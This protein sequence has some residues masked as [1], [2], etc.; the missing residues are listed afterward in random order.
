M[1]LEV[2]AGNEG[3]AT[4]R[5]ADTSL[6][7]SSLAEPSQ[8]YCPQCGAAVERDQHIC[9]RCGAEVEDPDDRAV[10]DAMLAPELRRARYWIL[11]LGAL[12]TVT[13]LLIGGFA[14]SVT[15]AAARMVI[16]V[17]VALGLIH[18]GLFFWAKTQPLAA[19]VV[20]LGLFI[21]VNAINA[22]DDPSTLA[23]GICLKVLFVVV[24]SG[25]IKAGL[26]ARRLRLGR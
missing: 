7:E 9:E 16:G 21:T 2:D 19:A 4:D 1:R 11:A 6:E 5:H 14:Y 18:L 22:I 15:P 17:N 25:A 10:F 23:Q 12:Y 13:G 3:S 26:S 24:L 20:A 8:L